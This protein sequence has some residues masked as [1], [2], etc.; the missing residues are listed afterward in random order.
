MIGKG[1]L[2]ADAVGQRV[3]IW[4]STKNRRLFGELKGWSTDYNEVMVKLEKDYGKGMRAGTLLRAPRDAANFVE[5][6]QIC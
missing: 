5:P 2:N 6:S 1:L 3:A 4:D